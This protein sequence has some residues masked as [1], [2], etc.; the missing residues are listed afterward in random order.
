MKNSYQF[1]ENQVI[2]KKI[3]Y[4][5]SLKICEVITFVQ[6]TQKHVNKKQ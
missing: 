4:K 3:D 1:N 2:Q 5:Y 6:N